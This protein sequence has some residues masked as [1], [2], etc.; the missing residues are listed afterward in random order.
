MLRPSIHFLDA[1]DQLG[2]LKPWLT[3][4]LTSAFDAAS[5]L[6]PL[7]GTDIVV[8]AGA[9]VIPEKGHVGFAPEIGVIYLTVDPGNPALRANADQSL[10]RMVL[11]ELH[12]SARWDGPGYGRTLGEALVSEGLAG[13]F[14]QE[15]LTGDPEP[16]E[17]LPAD[18]LRPYLSTASDM[19]DSRDYGHPAWF[20]GASD[21]PRW[22]GYS[23]EY[24]LVA[25]FLA[26]NPQAR[27]SALVH[28][29]AQLFRPYL[30]ALI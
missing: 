28:A 27:A 17:S 18:S 12:H 19:W 10:E 6:L 2:D 15:V 11:H 23:Q 16:W 25:K 1:R 9:Y 5:D 30:G 22:L 20:F 13:H 8:K 14:V 26:R 4:R 24:Q 7:G 29:R 3:E 21:M